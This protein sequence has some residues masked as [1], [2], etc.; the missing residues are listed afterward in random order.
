MTDERILEAPRVEPL[1]ALPN[2]AEL[3]R[4]IAHGRQLRAETTSQ[5]VASGSRA[6]GRLLRR[7]GARLARWQQQRQTRDALMGCSDRVLADVGIPREHIPLIARGLDPATVEQ[8]DGWPPIWWRALAAR[9]EAV[10]RA[11][12]DRRRVE[13]E[14]MAY[15]DRDLDEIGIRRVDI[16]TIARGHTPLPENARRAA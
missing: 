3:E 14:L 11:R 15:S 6:V 1:P 4:H 2:Y 8:R 7:T 13:G 9:I 10:R 12:R 5:M 16:P